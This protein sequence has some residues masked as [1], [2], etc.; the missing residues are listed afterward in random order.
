MLAMSPPIGE[1]L[2]LHAEQGFFGA[3]AVVNAQSDAVV[4]TEL[5]FRDITAQM[6]LVAVL[7]NTL[8]AALED[9]KETLDRVSMYGCILKR[10]VLTLAVIDRAV[11]GGFF[12]YLD[13]V[14]CFVGHQP[15]LSG[16]VLANDPADFFTGHAVDVDSLHLAAA[17]NQRQHRVLV[18]GPALGR[19]NA[20][21]AAD[22][23]L[24]SLH[25]VAGTAEVA[26]RPEAIITHRL[27][28]AMAQEPCTLESDA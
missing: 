3:H 20:L 23:G 16:E 12:A 28:D 24:V 11:A 14:L 13:V 15:R 6:L 17:L 10:D 27:A 9:G 22:E 21:L 7:I 18:A 8:H 19:R 26:E 1:P 5:K 4:V 2:P 25:G